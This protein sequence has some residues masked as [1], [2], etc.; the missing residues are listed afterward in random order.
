MAGL[1]L[2]LPL[3][4]RLGAPLRSAGC[5]PPFA[6]GLV[7]RSSDNSPADRAPYGNSL[8]PY[9][10]DIGAPGRGA[11]RSLAMGLEPPLLP[12]GC[13]KRPQNRASAAIRSRWQQDRT[14]GASAAVAT[15]GVPCWLVTS[16]GG[17]SSRQGRAGAGGGGR[18]A[19]LPGWRHRGAP[20]SPP[21]PKKVFKKI[22]QKN[23]R[24]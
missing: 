5:Q 7:S 4:L 2:K 21:W 11:Q 3:S 23:L 24:P 1:S 20:A 6:G 17:R 12:H 15:S 8:L 14:C 13:P 19:R 9:F 16:R 18:A 22:W 10:K